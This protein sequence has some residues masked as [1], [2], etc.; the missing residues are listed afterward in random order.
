[1][2]ELPE[3]VILARQIN[4]TVAGKAIRSGAPCT[5]PLPPLCKT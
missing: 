2:F 4:E 3:Y 5:P 1:M